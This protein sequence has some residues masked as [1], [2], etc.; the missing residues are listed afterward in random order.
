MSELE[1]IKNYLRESTPSEI[2][3]LI[4]ETCEEKI[5]GISILLVMRLQNEVNKLKSSI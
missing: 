3:D 5:G 4:A 2:S 1:I